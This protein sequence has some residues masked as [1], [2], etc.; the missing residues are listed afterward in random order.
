MARLVLGPLLR[1]V[2]ESDATVWVETDGPC[3]VLVLGSS[4]RTFE[5][6][7]HHYAILAIEGLESGGT[8]PYEVRLDGELAWPPPDSPYPPSTIRT[9]EPG[10]GVTLAFGSCR[11]SAPHHPPFSSRRA[12]DRRG[13]GIDALRAY[14]LRCAS[15]DSSGGWADALLML[16]D[17][18]YADDTSPAVREYARSRQVDPE[19]PATQLEDFDEY[20]FAYRDAWSEPAVRW[21]LS[22]LPSAMI[23]DDHEIHDEWKLSRQWV[24]EMRSQ[25]WYERRVIDGLAAYWIYQHLGNLSPAELREDE[26]LARLRQ[27]DDGLALLREFAADAD[28]FAERSRWSFCRDLGPARLV[29]FDSRAARI[30]RPGQREILNPEEWEWISERA[31]GEFTH[32]LLASSVPFLLA[33]GLHDFEAWSER[34]CDGAW[35]ERAARVG[36]RL[37]R[38]ANLGHWAAFQRSFRRFTELLE[39]LAKGRD[40]RRPECI[41]LLSGDVHHCYLAEVS[42]GPGSDGQAPVWQ[43]VCS[44]FRKGLEPKEKLAMK[45]GHSRAGR[46]L[47]G[48]LRRAVGVPAPPLEWEIV[49]GPHYVNQL[50][51]LEMAPGGAELRIQTTAGADWRRPGLRSV[52][53][54][55]LL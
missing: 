25:D 7:G 21:L 26:L 48:A 42:F 50:G 16:G 13:R 43:A 6:G 36:E 46:L 15:S 52:I 37:R 34:L 31:R 45:L 54:R 11:A 9:L 41:V 10:R 14:A 19:A 20:C 1:H 30:L 28:A 12:S 51:L 8:H 29:V 39:S 2:G 23:F 17:Q 53:E 32:L 49:A 33:R 27:G 55:R 24:E 47:G 35:G 44:G 22:T 3:E 40:G 18:I 38:R 4:Q 5:V